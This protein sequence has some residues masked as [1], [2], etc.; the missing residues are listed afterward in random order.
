MSKPIPADPLSKRLHIHSLSLKICMLP[1]ALVVAYGSDAAAD[2]N[3]AAG[4]VF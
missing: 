2:A 1:V 3:A 4:A